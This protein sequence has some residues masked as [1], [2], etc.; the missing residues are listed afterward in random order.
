MGEVS[1]SCVDRKD[2]GVLGL[3]E[4]QGVNIESSLTLLHQAIAAALQVLAVS[5]RSPQGD[6][7]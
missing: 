5:P 2:V 6:L 3:E 7:L 1:Y 4:E